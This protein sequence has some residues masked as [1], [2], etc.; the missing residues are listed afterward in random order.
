MNETKVDYLNGK[1]FPMIL[2]FSIP[3]AISLL[4]T[5]I[6]N[7]V[8]RMF[9]GNFNGTSALA[10][11]SVCFPLSYMMM[12][13]ALTCSAGGSTFFSL[14][15]GQNEPE[16]MNQS[17]GNAMVLVCVFEIILSA[18]LLLF[19]NPILKVFGVT[20][21]AYPYAILYYRIVALGC[22]FQG[23]SQLFCDFVRVSG[24]P[25][26]GMCVTGIGAVTNIILDAVFI[27]VF[28]W[29]VTGAASATVIGQIFSALFGAYLVFGNRTQ[30]KI[31]KDIFHLNKELCL[32][33]ISCGFAFWV[34]QMAMGFISLVYNSQLGKYGGDIA[35][36]VYAVISSIMTF[37]IMPA[38]GISQGIQPIIGNNYGSGNYRRVISTLCQAVL[39][40]VS[41]TCF[42]WIIVLAFPKQILAA[43]G[44]TEEMFQIGISGLRINFCIT[45]VLGF[46]ML[47][48][49]FFQ[50]INRPVPSIIITVLRQIVFLV[51]FIYILPILLEIN[52][53][54]FA[55]P[56]SDLLA[57][58]LS[59]L[60]VLKEKKRMMCNSAL[61]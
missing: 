50:S 27:I 4:I 47:A 23:L 10:G 54:F 49:T 18:L 56:I 39:F 51:P 17:F 61:S 7:I 24:K 8:D 5:A 41:I 19:P 12:A 15:S 48:T 32:Q 28:D 31:S 58:A 34:A 29:G 21:T 44:G 33:I 53:I 57:T 3:A 60:L 20:E 55:Q 42:I 26:L 35:I 13:F 52:G 59:V 38:S 36:S 14:F 46:V 11:L 16:K 2:K 6:Y 9:V 1:L 45:P 37:V 25:V 43:F 40:S 30:V 22:I